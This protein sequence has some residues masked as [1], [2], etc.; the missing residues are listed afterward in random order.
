MPTYHQLASKLDRA[1]VA[2]L[3]AEGVSPDQVYAGKDS[4][5]IATLPAV[6]VATAQLN[7]DGGDAFSGS[8][9]ATVNIAVKHF[10]EAADSAAESA[11]ARLAADALLGSVADA[12]NKQGQSGELLCDAINTA[13]WALAVSDPTNHSD[14]A[15]FSAFGLVQLGESQGFDSDGIWNDVIRVQIHCCPANVA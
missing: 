8:R 11:T 12:M 9:V 10:P 2:Y 1:I 4:L 15:S 3:V 13:A 14:L 5:N 7:I 6:I